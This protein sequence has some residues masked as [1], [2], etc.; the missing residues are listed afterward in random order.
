MLFIAFGSHLGHLAKN[1]GSWN[2]IES[3]TALPG[4]WSQSFD[5]IF[6]AIILMEGGEA[7]LAQRHE[8]LIL[9]PQIFSAVSL[10]QHGV[11][12]I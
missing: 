3:D 5:K 1:T 2:Q 8:P 12:F 4:L 11:L 9:N 10:N 6:V 7:D